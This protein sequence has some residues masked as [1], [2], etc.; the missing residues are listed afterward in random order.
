MTSVHLES[1]QS[2]KKYY[3]EDCG[4]FS[5]IFIPKGFKLWCLVLLIAPVDLKFI[6]I[7]LSCLFVMLS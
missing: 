5:C 1:K 4:C 6:Y 3:G 2:N 7:W